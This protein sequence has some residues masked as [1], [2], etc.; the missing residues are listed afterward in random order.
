MKLRRALRPGAW[1]Q[2]ALAWGVPALLL[3]LLALA[4][5]ARTLAA[6]AGRGF[7]EQ[8]S[9]AAAPRELT[10]T[11]WAAPER[12]GLFVTN[13]IVR[14]GEREIY[15][16]RMH[17]LERPDVVRSTGRLDWLA[18]G[19][20]ATIALPADLPA[21][22]QPL[23]ASMRLGDGVEFA[24]IAAPAA[25]QVLVPTSVQPSRLALLAALLAF[26][27]PLF[28][29]GAAGPIER[30]AQRRGWRAGSAPKLFV[31][32][33]VLSFALLV[34]G[35]FT[36]SSLALLF[37]DAAPESAL[38]APV[39]D[40]PWAGELRL[41]RSD[42]W[43]VITP[44]ALAQLAHEPPLPVRNRNL[45]IDG[46]NM[47]VIGMTGVPVAHPSALARP[48]TWGF[49]ALDLRRALAWYWWFPFFACFGVVA[50]LLRRLCIGLDW[51][52]AAGLSAT[53]ALAPYSVVFSGWPAY[54]VFF[55]V[56]ALLLVERLLR[57]RHWLPA[58]AAGCAAG[59]AL[60]GF[61]L[62]LYPAWQISL[63]WLLAPL[64]LAWGWRERRWLVFGRAQ[65]IGTALALLVLAALLGSWW[66]SAHDAV[67]AIR[68]TVYPGQRSAEV[69]GDIDRW[70][71]LKGLLSPLTMYLPSA[72]TNAADAGSFVFLLL[73]IAGA[74]LLAWAR[75]RRV[76]GVALVVAGFIASVLSFM[77]VGWPAGLAK[78][79]LLSSTT[80]YRMD[81]ALGLA[82]LLLIGW[83]LAPQQQRQPMRVL[84]P[85]ATRA[86]AALLALLTVALA[87]WQS[88][89]LPPELH[90]VLPPTF[91]LLTFAAL[92]ACAWL[93]VMQRPRAF[94]ALFCGWT[95]ASALPFNPLGQ[96]PRALAAAPDVAAL[97]G[98]R[99]EPI[100]ARGRIAVLDQRNWA[101]TLPA[102]GVAVL[103]SVFYDPQTSL[104]R[105]LDPDG[106]RRV[107]YNRYQR[108][109]LTL[110][111]VDGVAAHRI[112]SPRLD[113]VLVTLDPVRF[114]FRLLDSAFVL[115]PPRDADA[116]Q[117]NPSL[118]RI[119]AGADGHALYR[120]VTSAA[121]LS[122]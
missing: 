18:S 118:A 53:V 88:R 21:G 114:D 70:F 51:R 77:F 73:P 2:T 9:V 98:G 52:I 5:P 15:R 99:T 20:R 115:A 23:T 110:G 97:I 42:E 36:G 40:R 37:Q 61:A 4:A 1:L 7:L 75:A 85:A 64:A 22:P 56:A 8:A 109:L 11:G 89:L 122:R 74:L 91:Q 78:A 107:L 120:V 79:T 102:A 19:F 86:I 113:E 50:A 112:D 39:G 26:G 111:T 90:A 119:D 121:P 69:G 24:L 25:G 60:S 12:P 96:A 32:S 67:E 58:S 65:V 46:Q 27:A 34:A 6:D 72:A 104:W 105:R 71:L 41:V 76:D 43:Q 100:G 3:F 35:G 95:L 101:M 62:V 63:A 29:L 82:Q 92:A 31:A 81:L 44:L 14:I 17:R 116:L 13:L 16:G 80:S 59:V 48:A 30:A 54:T 93:L 57:A 10:L 87:A 28:A 84:A 55:A 66:T 108:L 103:N 47:L 106:S 33:T 45:G 38:V 68:A 117:A 49:F 83:L 94:A